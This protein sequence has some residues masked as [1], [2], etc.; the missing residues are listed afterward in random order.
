MKIE[1]EISD[2][3]GERF[4]E[5]GIKVSLKCKFLKHKNS[6]FVVRVLPKEAEDPR[7]LRM[8]INNSLEEFVGFFIL[9]NE[10][11]KVI[12][13]IVKDVQNYRKLLSRK[14]RTLKE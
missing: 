5:P 1:Y 12:D 9:D 3:S 8:L 10:K 4:W 7:I 6:R 11:V 13:A 14:H 2:F